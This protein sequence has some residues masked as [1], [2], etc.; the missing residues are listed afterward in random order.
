MGD[1]DIVLRFGKRVFECLGDLPAIPDHIA[2][3]QLD[4]EV[5]VEDRREIERHDQ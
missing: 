5:T 3:F 4:P 1:E 2:N